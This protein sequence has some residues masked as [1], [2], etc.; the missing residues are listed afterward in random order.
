[1][2]VGESGVGILNYRSYSAAIPSS[3]NQSFVAAVRAKTGN[4]P[5]QYSFTGYVT[6]KLVIE[7]LNINKGD[8]DPAAI[9][10]VLQKVDLDTPAGKFRFDENHQAVL[11]MYIR[12]VAKQDGR[13]ENILVD[14]VMNIKAGSR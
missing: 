13:I 3:L 2:G 11:N 9:T 4:V 14:Q 5:N 12:K 7:A 10:A 8:T 1:V 6:A